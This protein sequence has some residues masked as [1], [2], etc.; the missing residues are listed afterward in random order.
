MNFGESVYNS[1]YVRLIDEVQGIDHHQTKIIL[2]YDELKF[3]E[4]NV[5]TSFKIP[6][7]PI[8]YDSFEIYISKT[9]DPN[10]QDEE[11]LAKCDE[12]GNIIGEGDYIT[13][14]SKVD[15]INGDGILSIDNSTSINPWNC[16]FRIKYQYN[17]I[18]LKNSKRNNL[19]FYTDAVIKLTYN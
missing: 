11:L 16:T 13:T 7:C 15:L 1:D 6:E 12:N 14:N 17:N 5:S 19:L 8:K 4:D 3:S 2:L 10:F 18:N 9:A